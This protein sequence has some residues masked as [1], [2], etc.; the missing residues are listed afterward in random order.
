[1]WRL[2]YG[3]DVSTD[4]YAE[5]LCWQAKAELRAGIKT[6][7]ILGFANPLAEKF[8]PRT[9]QGWRLWRRQVKRRLALGQRRPESPSPAHTLSWLQQRRWGKGGRVQ[10]GGRPARRNGVKQRTRS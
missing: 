1:M 2:A 6:G 3:V 8:P 5:M 7:G 10:D 4:A 9:A